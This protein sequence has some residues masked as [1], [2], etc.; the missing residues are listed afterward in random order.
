MATCIDGI[1]W[2]YHYFLFWLLLD[3]NTDTVEIDASSSHLDQRHYY[4]QVWRRDN[5]E[6]IKIDIGYGNVQIASARDGSS[7]YQRHKSGQIWKYI[8]WPRGSMKWVWLDGNTPTI[9]LAAGNHENAYILHR[10]GQIFN[11]NGIDKGNWD[12][13][14]D[15]SDTVKIVAERHNLY[16]LGTKGRVYRLEGGSWE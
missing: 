10:D 2:E 14:S 5:G 13:I 4:G 7:L 12:K 9:L 3:D 15:G 16:R 6:W 11:Y 1:L 8:S